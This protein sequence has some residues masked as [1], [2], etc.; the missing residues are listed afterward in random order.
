MS[1]TPPRIV[2]MRL[3]EWPVKALDAALEFRPPQAEALRDVPP[4]W[5]WLYFLR[6]ARRTQMGADGHP[7]DPELIDSADLRRRM[8]AAARVH[9]ERPLELGHTASMRESILRTRDTQGRSGPLRIVTFEYQY[10]QHGALCIREERDIVYL[11]G[12][13]GAAA[14]TANASAGG[15]AGAELSSGSITEF[16][17]DP[18]LLFRFS[19]LTFNAHR[20][21]YDQRYAQAAEGYRERIVHGP[22]VA[23][24]LAELLRG[25]SLAPVRRFEFRAQQPL[26]VNEPIRLSAADAAD[27]ITLRAFNPAGAVAMEAHAWV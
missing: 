18:V 4:L 6:T 17:P 25:R 1:V 19:A 11:P 24:L 10:H 5:H 15:G 8:F 3:E 21:H 9:F 23:I 26:F 12:A 14:G 13:V 16:T 27:R 7:A 2:E 20:I 22:L